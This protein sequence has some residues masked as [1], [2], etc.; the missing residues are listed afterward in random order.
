MVT[1]DDLENEV[2]KL[3]EKLCKNVK[4]HLVLKILKTGCQVILTGKVCK[5]HHG[6]IYP[7]GSLGAAFLPIT[8]DLASITKTYKTLVKAENQGWIERTIK[9]CET[10]HPFIEW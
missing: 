1:L 5:K 9:Y 10:K 2:L 7:D 3:N 8:G 6:S 4:N